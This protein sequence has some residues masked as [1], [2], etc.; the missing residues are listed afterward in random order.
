MLN[1]RCPIWGRQSYK[2]QPVGRSVPGQYFTPKTKFC[3]ALTTVNYSLSVSQNFIWGATVPP[4]RRWVADGSRASAS[5]LRTP[6]TLQW[7]CRNTTLKTLERSYFVSSR[8]YSF[9]RR[10]STL[11]VYFPPPS[12]SSS[13]K[14]KA[15]VIQTVHG[16]TGITKD[17]ALGLCRPRII[18]LGRA[19]YLLSSISKTDEKRER[20][21]PSRWLTKDLF[22]YSPL[23]P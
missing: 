11:G 7:W 18:M 2:L 15:V 21:R 8:F 14:V 5:G 20:Y 16:E 17:R 9:C 3:N 22:L 12:S 1:Q 19:T 13:S 23:Q 4:H 10:L 6:L